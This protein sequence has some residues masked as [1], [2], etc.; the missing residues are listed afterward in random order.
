LSPRRDTERQDWT[1]GGEDDD[2][3]Q[4][5]GLPERRAVVLAAGRSP[6]RGNGGS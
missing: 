1:G 2:Q 3:F 5:L 6:S 4:R